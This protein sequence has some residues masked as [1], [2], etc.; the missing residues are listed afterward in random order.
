LLEFQGRK[1]SI[2][3]RFAEFLVSPSKVLSP[4]LSLLSYS[5]FNLKESTPI[6]YKVKLTTVAK[7]ADTKKASST[8][9]NNT[10]TN[11]PNQ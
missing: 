4:K 7:T 2:L 10:D 8:N 11:A 3:H 5:S 9:K 6:R 1:Y